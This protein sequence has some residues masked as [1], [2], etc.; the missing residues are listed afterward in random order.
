MNGIENQIEI[1]RVLIVPSNLLLSY[2]PPR[3]LASFTS[4]SQYVSQTCTAHIDYPKVESRTRLQLPWV[5]YTSIL[6][7]IWI[8]FTFIFILIPVHLILP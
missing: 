6:A 8:I 7:L 1:E 2:S 5:G 3:F 4:T